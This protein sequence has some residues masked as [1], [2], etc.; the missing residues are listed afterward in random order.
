MI[1]FSD[2]EVNSILM[3]TFYSGKLS[4]K[5]LPAGKKAMT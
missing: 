2:L 3:T 4:T 1:Q 5:A